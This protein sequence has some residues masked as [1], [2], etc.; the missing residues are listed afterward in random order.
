MINRLSEIGIGTKLRQY[1]YLASR[2]VID[3]WSDS[4]RQIKRREMLS[5]KM[6]PRGRATFESKSSTLSRKNIKIINDEKTRFN[7]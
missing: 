2:I 4:M 5:W 1:F 7:L 6:L 3:F